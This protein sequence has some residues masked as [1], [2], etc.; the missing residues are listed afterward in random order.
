MMVLIPLKNI[1][2]LVAKIQSVG[3]FLIYTKM[4]I[5]HQSRWKMT[6]YIYYD[7]TISVC[8]ACIYLDGCDAGKSFPVKGCDDF[9][10]GQKDSY[11]DGDA[12]REWK[13]AVIYQYH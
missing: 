11:P 6:N 9:N 2:C 4:M 13:Y 10:D 7:E 5:S 3:T 12:Y 1:K 8:K